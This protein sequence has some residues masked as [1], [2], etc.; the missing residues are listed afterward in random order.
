M[1]APGV[2]GIWR[3]GLFVFRLLERTCNYFQGSGEQPHSSRELGSSA[4][5][6]KCILKILTIKEKPIFHL[7]FF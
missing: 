5:S 1:W 6:E 4:E 3:Q 2:L 7:T